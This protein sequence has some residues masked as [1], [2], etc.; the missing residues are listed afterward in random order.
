MRNLPVSAAMNITK[1]IWTISIEGEQVTPMTVLLASI[2]IQ[3][4]LVINVDL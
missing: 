3:E 1:L 4:E 2:V